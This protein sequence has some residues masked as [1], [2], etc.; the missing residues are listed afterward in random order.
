MNGA[1]RTR[2]R[3]WP[4]GPFAR[5]STPCILPESHPHLATKRRCSDDRRLLGIQT[6][7]KIPFT[8]TRIVGERRVPAEVVEDKSDRRAPDE[9]AVDRAVR[10]PAR[11]ET[12]ELDRAKGATRLCTSTS[13]PQTSIEVGHDGCHK[14]PIPDMMFDTA[15]MTKRMARV[16]KDMSWCQRTVSNISADG[17][18]SRRG[19]SPVRHG[20][21][22][23][24][25]GRYRRDAIFRP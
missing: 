12:P 23:G 21:C 7:S 15:A 11:H 8:A 13:L 22:P 4:T 14:P 17:T 19:I 25:R 9:P 2:P 16:R 3:A 20:P 24:W 10:W 1:V 18:V 6:T 5:R